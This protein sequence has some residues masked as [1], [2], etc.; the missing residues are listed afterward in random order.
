[1]ED[2]LLSNRQAK[3]RA[4]GEGMSRADYGLSGRQ[5]RRAGRNMTALMADNDND[6]RLG[7]A[8][9]FQNNL[10]NYMSNVDLNTVAKD[11]L[12]RR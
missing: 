10:E 7:Q 6:T 1:M 4:L 5:A 11:P 3:Y 9:Q 12:T 8:Q 2:N